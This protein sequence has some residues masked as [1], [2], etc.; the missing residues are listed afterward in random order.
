MVRIIEFA[1]NNKVYLTTKVFLFMANYSRKLRMETDIKRK[2]KVEKVI[3]FVERT[4][5]V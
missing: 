5:K 1:I 4:K 3:E 2:E